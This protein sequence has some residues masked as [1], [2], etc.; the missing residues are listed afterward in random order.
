ML[1]DVRR[2]Y[3]EV[4]C[5]VQGEPKVFVVIY[6]PPYRYVILVDGMIRGVGSHT[7]CVGNKNPVS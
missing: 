5:V 1:V 6:Y 7:V 3:S 4:Q 2:V